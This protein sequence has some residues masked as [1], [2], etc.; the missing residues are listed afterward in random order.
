MVQF[1]KITDENYMEL[2]QMKEK[3]EFCYSTD[4]NF[5]T[6]S[7]ALAWLNRDK[8]NTFPFAI[9]QKET[10][11]GFMMLAHKPDEGDLHLW[12]FMLD[13]EYRG[14]G[15][16]IQSVELLIQLAKASGKYARL[17]LDCSP[18]NETAVHIYRKLGFQPTGASDCGVDEYWLDLK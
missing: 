17:S 15:Y 12:R 3:K 6:D 8:G 16:G 14:R 10:L 5:V 1:K 13:V 18:K 9:Y 11:I 7:L 4:F 2:I